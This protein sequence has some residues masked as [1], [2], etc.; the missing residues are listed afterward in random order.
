MPTLEEVRAPGFSGFNPTKDRHEDVREFGARCKEG[1]QYASWVRGLATIDQAAQCCER[2]TDERLFE[3]LADSLPKTH[4]FLYFAGQTVKIGSRFGALRVLLEGEAHKLKKN[5]PKITFEEEGKEHG[6]VAL[7]SRLAR[8]PAGKATSETCLES[9]SKNVK[10]RYEPQGGLN[11][12]PKKK[13]RK[14]SHDS[15]SEEEPPADV[16]VVTAE[17]IYEQVMAIAEKNAASKLECFKFAKG[18]CRDEQCRWSQDSSS[19]NSDRRTSQSGREATRPAENIRGKVLH[20]TLHITTHQKFKEKVKV[21]TTGKRIIE[22][23]LGMN[24]AP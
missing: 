20:V 22:I 21:P 4:R 17:N 1:L 23:I 12:Q 6:L 18:N 11:K 24:S 3:I 2:E 13:R 16:A 14:V 10:T 8:D 19:K 5:E 7:N 9:Y 15:S